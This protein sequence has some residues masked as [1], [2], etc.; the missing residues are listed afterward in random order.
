MDR[1]VE[2]SLARM[3]L[4]YHGAVCSFR[5]QL[6]A[7][8]CILLADV[9]GGNL[10]ETDYHQDVMSDTRYWFDSMVEKSH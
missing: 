5:R 2:L 1:A 10:N 9:E 7:V 4:N 8:K 3:G 6:A